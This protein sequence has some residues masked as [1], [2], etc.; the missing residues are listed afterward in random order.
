MSEDTVVVYNGQRETVIVSQP[1]AFGG[2]VDGPPAT[3]PNAIP[4][5]DSLTGKKLKPG[6]IGADEGDTIRWNAE[7][8]SWEVSAARQ[9][10]PMIVLTPSE[11]AILNQEGGLWYKSTDKAVYVCTSDS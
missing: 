10:F 5:W 2:D 11:E 7:T 4:L 6:L 1:A 8:G 3:V 9:E